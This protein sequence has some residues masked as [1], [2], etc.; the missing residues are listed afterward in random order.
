MTPR[1]WYSARDTQPFLL[2]LFRSLFE[3]TK[4]LH[5]RFDR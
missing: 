1:L 5:H 2:D 3:E 4:R